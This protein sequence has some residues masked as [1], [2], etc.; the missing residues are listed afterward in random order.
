MHG[1]VKTAFDKSNRKIKDTLKG[2][3]QLLHNSP[4]RCEDYESVP[5]STNCPLYY[6]ATL[7][8]E[9][10]VVAERMMVWPNIKLII[11]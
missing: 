9:N 8:V 7:W 6:C 11:F 1:S 3:F 4:A 5:R 10:K 2:G